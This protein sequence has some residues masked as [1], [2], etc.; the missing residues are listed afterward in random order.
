MKLK[1]IDDF[2]TMQPRYGQGC[3]LAAFR[4][5]HHPVGLGTARQFEISACEKIRV[6]VRTH[7]PAMSLSTRRA[8]AAGMG[9]GKMARRRA[10][11][12]GKGPI[13]LGAD[14][15][16]MNNSARRAA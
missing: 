14:S 15:R 7:S 16:W 13:L 8:C 3:R 9:W 2:Q 11:K 1:G 5:L 6:R 12:S 10:A 4:Q